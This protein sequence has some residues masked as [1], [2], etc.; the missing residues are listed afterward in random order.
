MSAHGTARKI[1]VI[2]DLET[3]VNGR[4]SPRSSLDGSNGSAHADMLG[5]KR[6]SH[7]RPS[8]EVSVNG[9]IISDESTSCDPSFSKSTSPTYAQPIPVCSPTTQFP[10]PRSASWADLMPWLTPVETINEEYEYED[11]SDDDECERIED[12]LLLDSSRRSTMSAMERLREKNMNT[13]LHT[14]S[15]HDRKGSSPRSSRGV[16][17][18]DDTSSASIPRAFG[19]IPLASIEA[20]EAPTPTRTPPSA[21]TLLENDEMC[22]NTSSV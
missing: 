14:L 9:D 3:S 17:L 12:Q 19:E 1:P 10:I 5:N 4:R 15:T 22:A 6:S 7:G 11:E 16:V 8:L 21:V 13:S 2:D 18:L 20:L